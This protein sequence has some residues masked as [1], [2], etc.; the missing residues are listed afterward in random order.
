M[1]GGLPFYWFPDRGIPRGPES[2][3]I[4]PLSTTAASHRTASRRG[5][6]LFFPPLAEV[7]TEEYRSTH[8]VRVIEEAPLIIALIKHAV[9]MDD[10]GAR[11]SANLNYVSPLQRST[12]VPRVAQ[13]RSCV[14][15]SPQ[16]LLILLLQRSGTAVPLIIC[17]V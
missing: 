3:D 8:R 9:I 16:I 17:D 2:R 5:V 13:S 14:S 11:S 15:L 1:V 7:Q 12:I 6:P 10:Y 4:G